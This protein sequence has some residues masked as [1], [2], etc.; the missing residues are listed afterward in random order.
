MSLVSLAP[1]LAE[2]FLNGRQKREGERREGER[3][4]GREI[5]NC[6]RTPTEMGSAEIPSQFARVANKCMKES[7]YRLHRLVF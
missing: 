3:K 1:S 4:G 2:Q 5:S 6:A 7:L